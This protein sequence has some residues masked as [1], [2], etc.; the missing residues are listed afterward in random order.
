[1]EPS[2]NTFQKLY[3]VFIFVFTENRNINSKVFD[4]FD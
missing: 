1:M 3:S 2:G 4:I